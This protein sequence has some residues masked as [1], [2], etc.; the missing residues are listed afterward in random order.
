MNG[1]DEN[2]DDKGFL[3]QLS[4]RAERKAKEYAEL[5]HERQRIEVRIERTKRYIEQLN[6][7]LSAEGLESVSLRVTAT[8][9]SGVGK[10]G[11]RSKALPLRKVQWEGMTV[12]QIIGRILDASP[13]VSYHSKEIAPQIYEIDSESDLNMVIGNLRSAMQT[14]A[15]NGLWERTSRARYGA[16]AAEAQGELVRT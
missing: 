6:D 12:D 9:R 1:N 5:L 13:N 16:K 10:P 4:M 15:R 14:G 2:Y 8:S 3:L 11:N 7:F